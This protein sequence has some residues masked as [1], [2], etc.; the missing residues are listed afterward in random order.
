MASFGW[1][2]G[3]VIAIATLAWKVYKACESAGEEYQSLAVDVRAMQALL[4]DVGNELQEPRS[5]IHKAGK[6]K[7]QQLL[8]L[9][10]DCN[11]ELRDLERYI[12]QYKSLKSAKPRLRDRLRFGIKPVSQIRLKLSQHTDGL[13]LF[14]T[15]INT[16]SLGRLEQASETSAGVLNDIRAKLDDLRHQVEIGQK[17]VS[18]LD[19]KSSWSNLEK[20]LVGDRVTERD[21]ASNRDSIQEYITTWLATADHSDAGREPEMR[22]FKSKRTSSMV[23][24][25]AQSQSATPPGGLAYG[26]EFS[27]SLAEMW[28][29]NG[30]HTPTTESEISHSEDFSAFSESVFSSHSLPSSRSTTPGIPEKLSTQHSDRD[31]TLLGLAEDLTSN[32]GI[33]DLMDELDA[34]VLDISRSST[35]E[36]DKNTEKEESR[37]EV[38]ENSYSADE[39]PQQPYAVA[40]RRRVV[41]RPLALTLEEAFSGGVKKKRV[42][43]RLSPQKNDQNEIE[44]RESAIEVPFPAGVKSG[45]R[46]EI[47]D[48]ATRLDGT[49][50]DLHFIVEL[51]KHD[52]FQWDGNNLTTVINITLLESLCGWSREIKTIDGRELR[53]ERQEV[54]PPTWSGVY[55][56]CGMRGS[57][58]NNTTSDLVVKVNVEY[59]EAISPYQDKTLKRILAPKTDLSPRM[60]FMLQENQDCF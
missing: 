6:S 14:L 2:A 37:L 24:W 1:S 36:N 31:S 39:V 55:R 46:I 25:T 45:F 51:K 16:S 59:P 4:Q 38:A 32:G 15:H 33:A 30:R 11:T 12:L 40:P 56:G 23:P 50:Q 57:S 26:P 17:D 8:N 44:L 43:G 54:T 58:K 20:E 5:V 35:P 42:K 48:V 53:I 49:V 28:N 21:V 52:S 60:Q 3:D 7:R 13:N 34:F 18:L 27:D 41:T 22:V 29:Y 10:D 47:P 9:L 19:V